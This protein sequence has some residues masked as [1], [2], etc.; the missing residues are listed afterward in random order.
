MR[1]GRAR[2]R[3]ARRRADRCRQDGRRRVRRAP[4]A[5]DRAQGVLH[6]AHQGAVEPE[7]QRPGPPV[8]RGA[9]RA[10]DGRHDAERRGA[11][12]RHDHRGAAQHAVR[13]VHHARRARVRGDGRGALPGRPV[14]RPGVGGGDHPP[15]RRRAAGVAVRHGVERRGVRG[16]AADR[17]RGHRR[18]GQRAPAR[19]AGPA[20]ARAG[21]PARPV[22]RPR[23]PDGARGEPADQPGARRAAAPCGPLGRRTAPRPARGP[24]LPRA[25]RP[26]ARRGGRAVRRPGPGGPP[27]RCRGPS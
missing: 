3:R 23:R 6:D 2:Q 16:L 12:G 22:R 25:G 4:R 8:R 5:G 19:P 1:G 13:R 26:A 7:V 9:R 18:G 15:A 10:A 24:G 27:A 11:R 14:P 21:R 20:R 17:A